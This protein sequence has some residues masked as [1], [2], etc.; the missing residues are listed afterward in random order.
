M[1]V[2]RAMSA[3]LSDTGHDVPLVAELRGIADGGFCELENCYVLCRL[4]GATNATRA[5]FD[6]ATGY[7]CFIN[8]LHIEDYE[9]EFPLAQALQFVAQVFHVWN[10]DR[11]TF[12]LRA[13]VSAD[14]FS[15]VAKFHA[16]RS[17]EHWLS[18]DLEAYDDPILTIDSVEDVTEQLILAGLISK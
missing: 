7:E 6:D 3:L 11:R 18:E 4:L 14:E 1:K 2:N 12:P 5:D 9:P 16:A 10:E 17:C 8:S 13:I 15:V